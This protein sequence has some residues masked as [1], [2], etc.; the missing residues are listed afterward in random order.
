MAVTVGLR[1]WSLS[2]GATTPA[3]VNLVPR[4]KCLARTARVTR[5][6]QR[7]KDK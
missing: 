4:L 1:R 3:D 7:R 6:R 2:V 5:T